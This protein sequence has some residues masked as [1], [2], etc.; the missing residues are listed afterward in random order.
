MTRCGCGREDVTPIER[1]GEEAR[2][3]G[4]ESRGEQWWWGGEEGKESG[5]QHRPPRCSSNTITSFRPSKPPSPCAPPGFLISL[6]C[7]WSLITS[8]K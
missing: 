3:L 7:P 8:H 5:N 2:E 1:K 4:V 6:V